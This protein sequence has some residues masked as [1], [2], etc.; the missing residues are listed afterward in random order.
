MDSKLNKVIIITLFICGIIFALIGVTFAYF[1]ATI[2]AGGN[3]INGGTYSFNATMNITT[4]KSGDLIPVDD[5]LIDDTLVLGS[6][7]LAIAP[8]L[9]KA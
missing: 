1:S 4:I 6:I 2:T 8:I 3:S 7:I 5:D 9:F